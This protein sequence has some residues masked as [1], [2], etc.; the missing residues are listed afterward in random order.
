MIFFRKLFLQMVKVNNAVLFITSALLI[1]L[2]TI[3]IVLVEKDTFPTLFDGFWWV[4]TTVTTV[5]YGDFYPV[6][7]AGRSIAIVLYV[8]GIGLIG[9]VIGKIID[10]LAVFRKKRLEGDIVY[11]ENGHF[12]IIGWSQKSH[13]AIKEILETNKECEIVIID[14][15]KEAPML[16]ENIHYIRGDAS[17]V[18][19]LEKSNISQARAVLI[20]A[21]DRLESEQMIDGQ[22]LLIASS[23][24]TVAPN[25]HTIA[26]V[27]EEKHIKNFKHA[28]ID[29]FIVSNETISSLAVRSAFRKGV[30]GIYSQLLKRSVGEDLF[31]IPTRP[32]WKT[33]RD[34]FQSLLDEGATLIADR[35]D[36]AINRKLSEPI[37]DDSEL[38]AVCDRDTY[39]KIVNKGE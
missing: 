35:N 6:S 24:E 13:F 2:S 29:E 30:S 19:T 18:E 28:Q 17:D 7:V 32:D 36:L 9:V 37:D 20:F 4:M 10:G 21:N 33:Y 25:V 22:T 15:M 39:E 5:G 34:A 31:Y 3:L 14:Q 16:S 26:E 1:I 12:I 27:M 38:Y 11:K 23:I 8:L